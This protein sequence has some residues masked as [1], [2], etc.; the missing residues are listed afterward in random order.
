[1][2]KELA[3][4]IHTFV[5]MPTKRDTAILQASSG[6]GARGELMSVLEAENIDWERDCI[7]SFR[8]RQRRRLT[9]FKS[10]TEMISQIIS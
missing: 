1:M 10:S 9:S 3:P 5:R 4:Q 8:I 6:N 7:P 2:K